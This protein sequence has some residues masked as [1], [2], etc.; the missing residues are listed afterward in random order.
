MVIL[1]SVLTSWQKRF[2]FS[3]Q[4]HSSQEGE[5]GGCFLL[6]PALHLLSRFFW[7]CGCCLVKVLSRQ[8]LRSEQ[9]LHFLAFRNAEDTLNSRLNQNSKSVK[10]KYKTVRDRHFVPSCYKFEQSRGVSFIPLAAI[11]P[12]CGYL[13]TGHTSLSIHPAAQRSSCLS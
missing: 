7:V 8:V 6:I 2:C 4:N 10:E 12:I 3:L 1:V 5:R 11:A 9:Q 13:K